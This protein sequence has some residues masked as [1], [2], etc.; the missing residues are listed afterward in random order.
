MIEYPKIQTLFLRDEKSIIIP[1]KFTCPEFEYLKNCKWE[2]TE[3]IDG[4]NMSIQL[5]PNGFTD[6]H[7]E[8]ERHIHGRTERANIPPL[9]QAKMEALFPME[10]LAKVFSLTDSLE[11]S[12]SPIIIYGEG[13][14]KKI[15]SC[16]SRYIKDD[17]NFILFDIKIGNWWLTREALEEI[18]NSLGIQI[19]PLVGY[20]TLTEAIEYV[21]KGFTSEVS[22]DE[23]LAAEG[24]V[25]KTPIGLKDRKGD[26]LITK[27]KTCDFVKWN[28]A[29]GGLTE[30]TQVPNKH[31]ES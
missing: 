23:A 16:G 9:L 27:I 13:Y 15:Q 5:I 19:V 22:E 1:D 11:E 4:T 25:L 8:W 18:A 6:G 26:R 24:L 29:Y 17:V 20:M 3:K 28:S 30:V 12:P 14:G 7:V 21:K 2:C 31:Y 10:L